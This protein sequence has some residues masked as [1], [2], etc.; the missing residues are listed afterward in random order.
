MARQNI[1]HYLERRYQL[2]PISTTMIQI[3]Q[4]HNMQCSWALVNKRW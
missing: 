4:A 1:Q 3:C 2:R